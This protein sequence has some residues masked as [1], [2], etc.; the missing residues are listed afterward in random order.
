MTD[1]PSGSGD[2]PGKLNRVVDELFSAGANK[3]AF[4]LLTFAERDQHRRRNRLDHFVGFLRAP[5]K[6]G[7]AGVPRSDDDEIVGR[8]RCLI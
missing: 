5:I 4:E 1:A 2:F 6:T 3:K 8:C 7:R